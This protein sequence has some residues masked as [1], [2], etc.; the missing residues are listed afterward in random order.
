MFPH[1]FSY[2]YLHPAVFWLFLLFIPIIAWYVWKQSQ[3]VPHVRMSSLGD[4]KDLKTS[5]LQYFLHSAF[6]LRLCALAL[7][8]C[9]LA[10]PVSFS[11]HSKSSTYGIDIVLAMDISSSMLAQDLRPDRL[12]AA[13][14][15]AANFINSRP[16]DRIALVVFS[17]ESFTQTPLTTDHA[18]LLNQLAEIHSGMIQDGTAIG[19]GLGLSINRLKEST[20]A[21]RIVV[22]LT[23]GVNNMGDIE[24][25]TAAE[26]AQKYGI[27]IYTIGV[28]TR[29]MAPYP[30]IDAYGKTHI[31]M[32]PVE[33]DEEML[34]AI[35]KLTG[36]QYFRATNKQELQ[37]IYDTIDALEKTK[38][39]D[40]N[41]TSK[42][43]EF[44]LLLLWALCLLALEIILKQT[45]FKRFP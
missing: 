16:N 44:P 24:P 30:L 42:Q 8:I 39:E 21:S 19:M 4:Y 2:T 1:L 14:E 28:G 41:M 38:I 37:K 13:K 32:A 18:T 15:V 11:I 20:A 26:L 31:Q 10:R 22:L 7:I 43:E 27:K 3:S 35:A 9:A 17:G 33:I 40:Y 45:I 5:L 23:D 12:E 25:I 29:G 34:T 6:V 36:G